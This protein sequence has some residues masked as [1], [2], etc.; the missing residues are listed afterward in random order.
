MSTAGRAESSSIGHT[1][2]P[3]AAARRAGG[4]GEPK[5]ALSKRLGSRVNMAKT[6]VYFCMAFTN[7]LQPAWMQY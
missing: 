4:H 3:A 2:G 6:R 7:V 5:E 1:G